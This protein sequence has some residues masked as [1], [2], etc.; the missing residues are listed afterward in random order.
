M[1]L[2]GGPLFH[3]KGSVWEGGIRVPALV[4]WPGQFPAGSVSRQVG[5]TMDLTA[6]IL[7]AAGV[8]APPETK[9]DGVNLLPILEE[10]RPRWSGH[11]PRGSPARGSSRRSAADAGSWSSTRGGRCSSIP[12]ATS[13]SAPT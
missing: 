13:A 4:R 2:A 7:A 9:L 12:P 5:M 1:A 3:R 10:G 6:S 8:A 11:C